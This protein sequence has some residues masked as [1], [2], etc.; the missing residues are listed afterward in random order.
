MGEIHPAFSD[1]LRKNP[2]AEPAKPTPP[3]A[4]KS[5]T[6]GAAFSGGGYK[7]AMFHLGSLIRLN[8]IG[9]LQKIDTMSSVSGGTITIAYLALHWPELDFHNGIATN[10]DSVISQPLIAFCQTQK[11]DLPSVVS[12]LFRPNWSAADALIEAYSTHLYPG[13]TLQDLPEPKAGEVPTF[14]FNATNLQLNTPWSFSRAWAGDY[15]VGYIDN[16]NDALGLVV[17]AS[18]AFPPVLSPLKLNV[19]GRITRD[20]KPEFAPA[21]DAYRRT[22]FLADGGIYDNMGL[23]RIS[24][25]HETVL[26]SNAGDPFSEEPSPPENWIKQ[27]RRTISQIHRHAEN[28]RLRWLIELGGRGERHVAAWRMSQRVGRF[29]ASM[30]PRLADQDAWLAATHEV[31]LTPLEDDAVAR[32]INHGYSLAAASVKT[33]WIK[34]APAGASQ[35]AKLPR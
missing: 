21:P 33:Y 29:G 23:E 2:D 16:P 8:E 32:L 14:Y 10:F 35:P 20:P 9:G 22:I 12:G 27:L 5:G 6:V 25:S 11:I 31:K 18:S 26:V 4:P 34:N 7:A 13:K 17:A 15:R 28:N 19:T 1:W 3:R 24:K 30:R